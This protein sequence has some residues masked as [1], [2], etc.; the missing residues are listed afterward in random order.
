MTW[1]IQVFSKFS[2]MFRTYI[3]PYTGLGII[4]YTI[5]LIKYLIGGKR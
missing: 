2:P 4:L 5:Y 3:L 1:F